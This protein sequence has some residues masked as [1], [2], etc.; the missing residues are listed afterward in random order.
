MKPPR[1]EKLP[2]VSGS[3]R[4]PPSARPSSH[5]ACGAVA[6]AKAT[7]RSQLPSSGALASPTATW[8]VGQASRL[9]LAAAASGASISMPSTRP[10]GPDQLGQDGGVVAR[11]HADLQHA[12]AVLHADAVELARPQQRLADIEPALLVEGDQHVVIEPARIGVGRRPVAV[13][14][15][16]DAP[17]PGTGEALA[18]HRGEGVDHALV[19]KMADDAQLLGEPAAG[20][21]KAGLAR[22]GQ[23][24]R[25]C[26][27]IGPSAR[28]WMNW[29]TWASPE[30]SMSAVRPCQIS[31]PS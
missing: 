3:S 19:Q 12:I 24:L 26:M 6:P 22:H 14:E 5:Q 10:F 31:L 30:W 20:L 27:R 9:R 7:I 28:P 23:S 2:A 25:T 21:R 17:R 8:A 13:G 11:A 15:V 16:Q 4:R 29:S 18:R 1:G